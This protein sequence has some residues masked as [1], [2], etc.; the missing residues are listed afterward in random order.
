MNGFAPA[1]RMDRANVQ[2]RTRT[3]GLFLLLVATAP[4]AQVLP[5]EPIQ[6]IPRSLNQDPARVAIGRRLFNDPRLSGNGQVS[7]ASCHRLDQ[8][9]ADDRIRS[10]GANGKETQV[11]TPTVLNAALNFRQFW[12]GRAETLEAQVDA[13][14]Q[15]GNEMGGQWE[16]LV[17]RLQQDADYRNAFAA[18]YPDGLNRKNIQSAIAA[19]ERTLLTPNS[20][21]DRYL[22]SDAG[23]ITEVEKSG[24]AKF[25]Q[26]GCVACHQGINVGGNMFQKF[27]V[28]GD[29]L[30]TRS[31]PAAA[32]LGRFAITGV[33]NDRNVFKVPSLR[34]VAR[35][36]PYFHDGSAGSLEEAVDV[37]FRIQLGRSAS[38]VD[39]AEIVQF[40][41][42]L[43]GAPAG[44][45]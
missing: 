39:K 28:M 40:L 37:M 45:P 21:F 16:P 13:V 18:A 14:V 10:I 8:G 20:R 31:D 3:W 30:R 27:G 15:N 32:D 41:G 29:Y 2:A 19:F 24:Y 26:F 38:A 36:A 11:N 35:T 33:E 7:C 34:N 42:T 17:E 22:S 6:P 5:D 12:D 4:H 43:S 23:A 1:L 9:G 25:K 44:V